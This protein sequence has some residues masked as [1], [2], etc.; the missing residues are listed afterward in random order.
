MHL[1]KSIKRDNWSM[2]TN[3]REDHQTFKL[4]GMELSAS[5][6]IKHDIKKD[7]REKS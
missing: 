7:R 1:L 2:L 5:Q 6:N 3:K 4:A